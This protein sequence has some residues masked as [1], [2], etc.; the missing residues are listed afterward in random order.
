MDN[1]NNSDKQSIYQGA[2]RQLNTSRERDKPEE[3]MKIHKESISRWH[4]DAN[5]FQ[6]SRYWN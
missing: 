3:T 1:I 5:K 2:T 4:V 6:G